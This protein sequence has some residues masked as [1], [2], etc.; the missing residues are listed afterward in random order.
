MPGSEQ[1]GVPK[2]SALMA[3]C[4]LREVVNHI[5]CESLHSPSGLYFVMQLPWAIRG[6]LQ[7]DVFS[8]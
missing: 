6:L 7:I 4:D 8:F 3:L 2:S 5:K 1:P